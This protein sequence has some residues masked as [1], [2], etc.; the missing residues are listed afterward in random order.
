RLG[1]KEGGLEKL[2]T[3]LRETMQQELERTIKNLL[4]QQLLDKFLEV[5]PTEIPQAMVEAEVERLK[6]ETEHELNLKKR[7]KDLS[8][9]PREHFQQLAE[10]RVTLG[11]LFAEFIKTHDMKADP[12]RVRSFVEQLAAAYQKPEQIVDWY[13]NNKQ[14]LAQIET[15]VLEEQ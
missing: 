11:L 7:G 12:D 1:I 4:K 15:R 13:Y 3:T 14:Q 2:K 8:N 10:I 5:N 6:H 9:F